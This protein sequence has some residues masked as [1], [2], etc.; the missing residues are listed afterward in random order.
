MNAQPLGAIVGGA[1]EVVV[2]R[3]EMAKLGN[4]LLWQK[5]RLSW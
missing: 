5:K 4:S 2:C 3:V 1:M